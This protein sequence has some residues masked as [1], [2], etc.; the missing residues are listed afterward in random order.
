[1]QAEEAKA[2]GTAAAVPLLPSCFIMITIGQCTHGCSQMLG[3]CILMLL[4]DAVQ[5][6]KQEI[7]L[8]GN[9]LRLSCLD[10]LR[11]SR[12]LLALSRL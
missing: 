3:C 12:G 4:R 6:E 11:L 2:A 1:M 10:C 9:S 7:E 5:A 8:P